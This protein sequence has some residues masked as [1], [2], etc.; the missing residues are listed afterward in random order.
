MIRNK[1]TGRTYYSWDEALDAALSG[2]FIDD[3]F[4]NR[5]RIEVEKGFGGITVSIK[6]IFGEERE[7]FL[8]EGEAKRFLRR[9][10]GGYD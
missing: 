5:R 7:R 9:R 8:D 2:E 10:G 6:T 3:D 4:L 1:H